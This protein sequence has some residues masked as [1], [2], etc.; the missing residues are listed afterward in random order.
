MRTQFIFYRWSTP[1]FIW[2]NQFW[3]LYRWWM[4]YYILAVLFDKAIPWTYSQVCTYKYFMDVNVCFWNWH[5][6]KNNN[7]LYELNF[8]SHWLWVKKSVKYYRVLPLNLPLKPL[9]LQYLVMCTKQMRDG[10]GWNLVWSWSSYKNWIWFFMEVWIVK[11]DLHWMIVV[12]GVAW[13]SYSC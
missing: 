11:I 2:P 4:V 5:I 10:L 3:R 7:R 12:H 8:Y 9:M 13:Q 1:T 6:V